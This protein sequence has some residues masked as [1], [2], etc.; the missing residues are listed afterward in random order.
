[1]TTT[2]DAG[3][4]SLRQAITDAQAA[5]PD[6]IVFDAGGRGT[7]TVGPLQL[8]ALST[9]TAVTGTRGEDGVPDV[10]LHCTDPSVGTGL[11]PGAGQTGVAVTGVSITNCTNGVFVP[12]GGGL[13]LRGSWIGRSRA[14]TTNSN[15]VNGVGA[16]A[17]ASL[18]VG[19]PSAGDGNVIVGNGSRRVGGRPPPTAPSSG[20]TR[21]AARAS[22]ASTSRTPAACS[23]RTTS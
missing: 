4:G 23:S 22:T 21:S 11:Q 15:T 20:A 18:V 6:D 13:T 10:E 17:G 5:G 2:A 14:G 3:A 9:G 7:I 8:P 12:A 16:L 19:G 1:M